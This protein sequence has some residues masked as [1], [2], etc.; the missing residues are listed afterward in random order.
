M[1]KWP[2]TLP[3]LTPEQQRISDDF[4]QHWHE[5]FARRYGFIDRFNHQYVV[6]HTAPGFRTTLE[7][8]AGLGEHLEYERLTP[9]QEQHYVAV[10]MRANMMAVLRQRF[11]RVQTRLQDCQSR[12]DFPDGYFDR[13]IA[14]HVLEHLP[15]LPAT[16]REM[17]RLCNKARGR[18]L[19]VIPCEGSAATRL[20]RACSA[21][22]IFEKRY[23]QPYD[24]F[25]Q[26]EHINR[27]AEI[28]EELEP[29][30][31]LRHRAF[32]PVPLPWLFCNLFIGA[33]LSPREGRG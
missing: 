17:H 22:R 19:M 7:I 12:L 32:F 3:P 18:L 25:I 24:W 28:F 1:S 9:E 10:D 21:R 30:F 15:N 33:T 8:G 16:V 20:A 26:R 4:M 2:K 23:G 14:V 11:P 6:R 29:Y 31:T 13:I 27:P 5:V